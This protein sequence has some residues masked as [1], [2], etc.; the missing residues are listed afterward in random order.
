MLLDVQG[1]H[2]GDGDVQVLHDVTFHLDSG[3]TITIVGPDGAG[4]TTFMCA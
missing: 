2:A 1:V 4:K 3:E